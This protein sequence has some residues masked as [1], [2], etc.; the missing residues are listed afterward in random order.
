MVADWNALLN[1]AVAEEEFRDLRKHGRKGR[2]LGDRTF[3]ERLQRRVGRTLR[4]QKRGP[5]PKTRAN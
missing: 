1:S 3:V 5:K 2:P 4:P